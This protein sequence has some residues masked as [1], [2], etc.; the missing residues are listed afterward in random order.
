V[1]QVGEQQRLSIFLP[2]LVVGGAER[3]MLKLAAGIAARGFAVD[4]VLSCARGELLAEAPTTARVVDL[5]AGRVLTCLPAL[6]RYLRREQPV[7]L[8]SVLHTNL[9]ALWARRLAN[10]RTRV[11]VSER[12]T[13]SSEVKHYASDP[14]MQLMPHLVRRFYPWADGII[15]V[16]KSVADDLAQVAGIPGERISVIYNPIITADL[17]AQARDRLLH[18]WFGD[19]Q[20]PVIL[21]TVR[22]SSE[23]DLP[24]LIQA[25]ATVRR[26]RPAR[27][28]I[29][30]E[31]E[32][33][34]AL[35]ALVRELGLEHDV[36]MPG[37][38][39]NPYP[40]MARAALLVLSSKWEGLPGVLIE[41]LYCGAPIVATDC[42]GGSREILADGRYGRLVPV[43][44]SVAMA[45]AMR[46]ALDVG[47]APS[48]PESW[49]PFEMETVVSQYMEVLL[50][51]ALR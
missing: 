16:S 14:R 9:V 11:L 51:H 35:E 37:F 40:Y 4:L 19:G 20:P 27:L 23:K 10:V 42:P 7:A 8:L 22:L 24:T 17:K 21:S 5:K 31:G 34:P 50:D 45:E 30:G 12:S 29:L 25:F 36:S 48:L 46:A 39:L 43:G 47:R 44:D 2:D 18:P 32:E 13:L 33:R 41:A 6:V 26:D 15:A 28:L 49:S 3:S 1:N 38:V